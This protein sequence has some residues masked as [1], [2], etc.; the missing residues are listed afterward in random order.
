MR[1]VFHR[2]F[3]ICQETLRRCLAACQAGICITLQSDTSAGLGYVPQQHMAAR[4]RNPMRAFGRVL[5]RLRH[6]RRTPAGLELSRQAVVN[7]LQVP[8]SRGPKRRFDQSTLSRWEDGDVSGLDALVLRELSRIYERPH[9]RLLDVLAANRRNPRLSE[10][11]ALSLLGATG[12][13]RTEG[14]PATSEGQSRQRALEDAGAAILDCSDRLHQLAD[15]LGG[16]SETI[17]GRQVSS[18]SSN[19]TSRDESH[20]TNSRPPLRKRKGTRVNAHER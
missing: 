10:E 15:H 19:A 11:D 20:R 17:F 3:D 14:A 12:D 16:I 5:G 18:G 7:L 6:A 2:R 1:A 8:S 9:D 4:T 13:E